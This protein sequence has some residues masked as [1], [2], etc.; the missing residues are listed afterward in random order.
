MNQGSGVQMRWGAVVLL[1]VILVAAGAIGAYVLMQRSSSGAAIATPQRT[2]PERLSDPVSSNR[3]GAPTIAGSFAGSARL[4]DVT[5]TLTEEAVERAGIEVTAV[6]KL[7]VGGRLRV[8]GLVQANAYRTVTIT[9]LVPG[10]VTRVLAELG[11]RVGRGQTIAEVYS[12]ELADAQTRYV[13]SRAELEAHERVLRR[14]ER[15]VGI[16][17]A[18]R[19]E[20]EK[21]HAEHTTATTVVASARSRLALLGMSD[22]QIASLASASDIGAT[23][24]IAAPIDGVVTKR[25]ANV[26]LNIEATTPLFTVVDL[27]SVWVVGD[28]YERDFARV[29]V[30]SPATVT[31]TA[32]PDLVIGGKVSYIDPQVKAET[33]TAQVRVEIPN[34][35]GQLRLGMYANVQVGD[36]EQRT[37]AAVPRSAVQVVGDRSVVYLADPKARGRFVERE[38]QLGEAA[39]DQ[40]AVLSGVQPGDVVV[41]KGS[42]SLRAE[43]ER[44]APR[45]GSTR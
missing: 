2:D 21:V 45:T 13:S 17:A 8:P 15:L 19:Q 43:R 27:S 16:G 23:T 14:T 39:D 24:N 7:G 33:R 38:V 42:F 9:S 34:R 40:V 30:G 6:T 41:T 32:Y 35:S 22:P 20:L 31:T 3:P 29:R 36:P 44:V 37:G 10:R 11:Q 28:L 5:I 4:P 12:P 26:G 18:S 1:A 25:D